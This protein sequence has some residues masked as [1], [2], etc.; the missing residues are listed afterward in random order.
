MGQVRHGSAMTTH[1]G[2]AIS[3]WIGF[4]NHRR[5][6]LVAD[7]MFGEARATKKAEDAASPVQ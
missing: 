6:G 5:D 4:Y 3:D 1:A 7:G 2:R